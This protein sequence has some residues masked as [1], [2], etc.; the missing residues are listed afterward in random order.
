M[1]APAPEMV[2]AAA[3]WHALLTSGE[4]TEADLANCRAWQASHPGHAEAFRRLEALLGRFE[5]LPAEPARRALQAGMAAAPG[6]RRRLAAGIGLAGLAL[7]LGI[8]T[9]WPWLLADHHAE[10]GEIREVTLPDGSR[11]TLDTGSAVD[12]RYD[13][14]TRRILLL[15]GDIMLD[16]APDAARPLVVETPQGSLRALG[17]RFTVHRGDGDTRVSVQESAV[18]ACA[19]A[20]DCLILQP[21][22]GARLQGQR[23][24]GP[25]AAP[26]Q[27]EAWAQG[28]LVVENRPL[29]EVLDALARYR[30]G[31]LRYDPAAIAHLRVSGVLP[32]RDTDKALAALAASLPVTLTRHTRFW[33]TVGPS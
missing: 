4:A 12:L 8:G 30:R 23:I 21:G 27:A 7:L 26:L 16:V 20:D 5:G 19:A 9:D 3:S 11:L 10:I 17:T 18:R 29:A 13:D 1:K 24:E 22:Q 6:A 33:V 31:V 15:R 25:F 14:A 2:R 28:V 32:L